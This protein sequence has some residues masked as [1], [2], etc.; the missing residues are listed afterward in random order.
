MDLYEGYNG[1]GQAWNYL[2]TYKSANYKERVN[3]DANGNILKYLRNGDTSNGKPMAM[4][5]LHYNYYAGTNRL[6]QVR[7]SV[8]AANYAVDID[9]QT[10]TSNYVYDPIGNLIQDKAEG[11]DSIKWNVY[12]KITDIYKHTGTKINYTYDASGNRISKTIFSSDTTV[13][14]YARDATGNVISVYRLKR[15]TVGQDELHMY[16]SSR[17]G[18]IRPERFLTLS[19]Q[20]G[21]TSGT[22]SLLGT[23]RGM[24]FTRGKKFFELTNHLGNVLVTITD[25]KQE[26]VKN[27]TLIHHYE[28][29]VVTAN[30]YYPFGMLEP[31]RNYNATG[32]KDYRYGFNRKE[33]DNEVKGEGEQQDYGMRIYDPRVGKFLSVDPISKKYPALTPYQFASNTPIQAI[34]LDGAEGYLDAV[35]IGQRNQAM[36]RTLDDERINQL[37]SIH[38]DTYSSSKTKWTTQWKN[39][40]NIIAKIS[41][42]I[43]NGFYTTGQQLGSSAT[44]QSEI[45]NIGG[46]SYDAHG[47][48]GAN[49]RMEHFVDAATAV[50]PGAPA[51]EKTTVKILSGVLESKTTNEILT[52]IETNAIQQSSELLGKIESKIL[53]DEN[54]ISHI[55]R[56]AE[57]HFAEST[58]QSRQVLEDVTN[59]A[60]NLLGGDKYGNGWYAKLN[61]KGE[62]IWTQVNNGKIINGG[63]NK[64]PRKFN[65]ETGLS[66]PIIKSP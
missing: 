6:R 65:A 63:I 18:M 53:I 13:T 22:I 64:V 49:Q 10:D 44:G 59:D 17:L 50:L 52:K 36:L 66:Q 40:N 7:D 51:A 42:S 55:F 61:E 45:N 11:I 27:D 24:V 62:Q 54:R 19:S 21:D 14:W 60:N 33:N 16:G 38:F 43:A 9:N 5:S 31:G 3:Y 34:D 1:V 15:D 47:A 57:G 29:D 4:D 37:N 25:R 26:V 48:F 46:G 20:Y 28:P 2:T 56:K 8:N 41:Y 58:E 30:D 23:W 39:S 32:A 35:H 12:G